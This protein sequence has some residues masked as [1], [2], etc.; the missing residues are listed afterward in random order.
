[1]LKT[2]K[3]KSL[4]QIF[5]H[6]KKKYN[7]DTRIEFDNEGL[8]CHYSLKIDFIEFGYGKIQELYNTGQLRNR[9]VGKLKKIFV[10]CL[11]HEIKHAIDKNLLIEEAKKIDFLRYNED[12][13]YHDNCIPEKRADRFARK[14]L[15]KWGL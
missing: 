13:K 11:L 5:K 15:R 1:M 2:K 7:L 10:F 12:R 3:E 4:L 14:E 6:Y 9:I 8:I